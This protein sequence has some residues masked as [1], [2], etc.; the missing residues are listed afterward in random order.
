VRDGGDGPRLRRDRPGLLT[1]AV[2]AAGRWSESTVR[3]LEVL[4]A[5]GR[6][7]PG[8]VRV[9]VLELDADTVRSGSDTDRTIRSLA[10]LTDDD[11]DAVLAGYQAAVG[12]LRRADTVSV[13]TARGPLT[14]PA[15]ELALGCDLRLLAHD[16]S[17]ALTAARSGTVPVL[18]VAGRLAELVGAGRAAELALTGRAVTATEAERIGLATRVVPGSDLPAAADE[19]ITA[20]LSTDRAVLA[21]T[22]ALFAAP[23]AAAEREAF[24]RLARAR[25]TTT[26]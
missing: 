22:K 10:S 25:F 23:T 15:V 17:L 24:A 7:L 5:V 1:V 18:G 13:A 26:D 19:L 3:T 21:E 9:V 16:A 12:W 2:D 11:C 14:G 6:E 4:A 8:D 20:L